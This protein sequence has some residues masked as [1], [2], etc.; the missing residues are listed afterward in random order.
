[1]SF[2]IYLF[3][4]ISLISLKTNS[5]Y[6]QDMS[7]KDSL[8]IELK[9]D[10]PD[11]SV[12]IELIRILNKEL[13]TSPA[14]S[15]EEIRMV[16]DYAN[17]NDYY[18]TNSEN[19]MYQ[20]ICYDL[21]GKFDSSICMYD[22][23]LV[24]ARNSN[25]ISMEGEIY[26]NYSITYSILGQL[27][28]SL[29]YGLMAME[30]YEQ[31]NDSGSM[32]KIYNNLG[33]RYSEIGLYDDAFD[34]YMKAI[35][36]NKKRNNLRRLVHNYGN[37][38]ADYSKQ[39]DYKTSLEYYRKAYEVQKQMD[40]KMNVSI[41]LHNMAISYQKLKQFK[42]AIFY[43]GMAYEIAVETDDEIGKL[44]YFFLSADIYKDQKEF[45]KALEYFHKA[46][47]IAD[48]IGAKQNAL[49]IY[50]GLADA[51]AELNDFHN[52]YIYEEKYNQARVDLLDAE[53]EK[54]LE[55]IKEYEEDKTQVEIDLLKK[56]SE[57]QN[58][59]I[60]RQK[61]IRHSV[62]I[63]GGLILIIAILIWSR[64][65]YVKRTRNKLA[66][67]NVII[68]DEKKKSDEL[69][70]NILPAETA[71]ELKNEG[72]SKARNFEMV[73]VLFTDFKGF[74]RIA[75]SMSPDK[76]VAEID[77]C[78]RAFDKIITK[79]NI[80]KIKTIGDA[81]MCA[82]GLTVSDENN[83]KEVVKAALEIR[84]FMGELKKIRI[85]EKRPFFE[86]RIG[87]HTGPVVAGIVGIKKFQYDIWGDTVNIA[88]RM[89]SSGEVGEVNVSE[90]TYGYIKDQF[91]C[92]HRGKIEAKNKGAID[93]YFVKGNKI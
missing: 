72:R 73:S 49:D 92:I 70:L 22:S 9:K 30:I 77:H 60:R 18:G 10:S 89:E 79:Y 64:Y 63:L 23:A 51:Y 32:A 50:K 61:I 31:A 87:I 2:R 13:F 33:N 28:K 88:S 4:F 74:T 3:V 48:S 85:A 80:E 29:E 58:L 68:E 14:Q 69:L 45:R 42:T 19:I 35:E 27:E 82:G 15:L 17:R 53:K 76:L 71:E 66:L 54:A 20:G 67:K 84:D 62:T 5:L 57:I 44:E 7:L 6:S 37:I 46:E 39:G 8:F 47:K 25:K 91:D 55:K 75:E 12:Y 21:M 1:M 59:T 43:A 81:Y 78:F 86:I 16:Y 65:R 52:A 93:M 90:T 11:T 41:L 24:I 38:G 34:F 56:D 83:P 26:N 40:Y 36:I